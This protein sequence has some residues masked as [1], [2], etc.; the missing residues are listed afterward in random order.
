MARTIAFVK[1]MD[2][3]RRRLQ[4]S[5]KRHRNRRR[6]M[7]GDHQQTQMLAA[8]QA[9]KQSSALH[10]IPREMEAPGW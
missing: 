9:T 10:A 5:W 8:S 4:Q 6:S 2:T 3:V 7:N 1:Y